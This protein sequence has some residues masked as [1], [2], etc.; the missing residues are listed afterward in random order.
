M[1]V[2]RS[3]NPARTAAASMVGLLTLWTGRAAGAPPPGY[4]TTSKG[5]VGSACVFPVPNGAA[6]WA[7]GNVTDGIDGPLLF[8]T[9]SPCPQPFIPFSAWDG[10]VATGSSTTTAT[11]SPGVIP[12]TSSWP[13]ECYNET[14][15]DGEDG[16]NDVCSFSYGGWLEN[17]QVEA[18]SGHIGAFIYENWIVPPLPAEDDGQTI[19][20]WGGIAQPTW[21]PGV[22]QPI[23]KYGPFNTNPEDLTDPSSWGIMTEVVSSSGGDSPGPRIAVSPGDEIVAYAELENEGGTPW[24]YIFIGDSNSGAWT[25]Q[26]YQPGD[27]DSWQWIYPAVLEAQNFCESLGDLCL[28]VPLSDGAVAS[29]IQTWEVPYANWSDGSD[30]TQLLSPTWSAVQEPNEPN[31]QH[32]GCGPAPTTA[33]CF[34]D[35][36]IGSQSVT[37]G[38]QPCD[39]CG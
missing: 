17:A 12:E 25:Y 22:V 11:L 6:V 9:P 29:S 1:T 26:W 36:S 34:W 35:V 19:N 14:C 33:A 13:V 20:Y 2:I 10:G 8:T 4:V 24:Y 3:W 38:S 15:T 32:T 7:N 31:V 27:F 18:A 30:W 21:D 28:E 39:G 5:Y 37:L 23:L 16:C